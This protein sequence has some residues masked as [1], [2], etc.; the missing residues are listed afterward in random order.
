MSQPSPGPNLGADVSYPGHQLIEPQHRR[1]T[2][3]SDRKVFAFALM[4]Y[5]SG[6]ATAF[7]AGLVAAKWLRGGDPT[8][9]VL[10]LAL[11]IIACP[12]LM[13]R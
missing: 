7:A 11:G 13:R 1:C 5:L 6:M 9:A 10:A 4:G 8:W 12:P 3:W 2:A